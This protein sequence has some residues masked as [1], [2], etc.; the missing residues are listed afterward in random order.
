MLEPLIPRVIQESLS[1]MSDRDRAIVLQR[2]HDV[3]SRP[4]VD[5][6]STFEINAGSFTQRMRIYEDYF[7]LFDVV[8]IGQEKF[9]AIYEIG[10]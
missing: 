6:T 4:Q 1:R 9:V 2:I 3:C 5:N 10:R 7:I 8:E